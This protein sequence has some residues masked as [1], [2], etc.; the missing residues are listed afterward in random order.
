MNRR[1]SRFKFEGTDNPFFDREA[2]LEELRNDPGFFR[3]LM[4]HFYPTTAQVIEFLVESPS[5]ALQAPDWLIDNYRALGVTFTLDD[6]T[7]LRTPA[8]DQWFT[9][10]YPK[11]H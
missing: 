3:T 4:P 8:N 1:L 7:V 10:V 9:Q 6:G 2:L 5:W 11:A